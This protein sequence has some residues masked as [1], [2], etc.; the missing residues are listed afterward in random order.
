MQAIPL[1]AVA[2]PAQNASEHEWKRQLL[3]QRGHRII[4]SFFGRYKTSLVRGDLFA[5]QD[6]IRANVFEYI[7]VFYNR[8]RKYASLR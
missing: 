3:R 8:F 7:E 5:N 2:R 6:E 1:S 4:E